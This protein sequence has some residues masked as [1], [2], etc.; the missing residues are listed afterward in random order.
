MLAGQSNTRAL[1]VGLLGPLPW[2]QFLSRA[3]R[4]PGRLG[5]QGLMSCGRPQFFGGERGC[6]LALGTEKHQRS[7]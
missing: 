2:G 5:N 6:G 1:G 3:G 7:L 4:S